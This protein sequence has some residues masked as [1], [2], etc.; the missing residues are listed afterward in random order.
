MAELI[1]K[2]PREY[3]LLEYQIRKNRR[4]NYSLRA[5]ARDLEFSPSSLNDFLKK[6]VGMSD[7]RIDML[8][9]KLGWSK[10]RT[11]YFKDLINSEFAKETSVRKM[12]KMRSEL[13]QKDTTSY[14]NA[15]QFQ[16]LNKWYNYVILEIVEIND[17]IQVKEI[18]EI[19][20]ITQPETQK[21]IKNLIKSGLII[22]TPTGLKPSRS[23]RQGGDEKP[24]D[25]IKNLHSQILQLAQTALYEKSM[26]DRESHSLIFSI[27]N[28]DK[29]KMNTEI[30]KA[31]YTIVNKYATDIVP[32]STQIISFQSFQIYKK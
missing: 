21:A 20:K 24:S 26:E 9:E 5:F 28:E 18:S 19:L 7:H 8:S 17:H 13:Q 31:L 14:L 30:R 32:D 27:K 11:D 22:Q 3:I 12:S 1:F 16:I 10:N 25:A 4:S 23:T 6:R 29:N 15:E 2:D